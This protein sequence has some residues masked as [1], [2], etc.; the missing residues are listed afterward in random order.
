MGS[1]F[2][3][4]AV[5]VAVGRNTQGAYIDHETGAVDYLALSSIFLSWFLV[6]GV[7]AGLAFT[8]LVW[9]FREFPREAFVNSTTGAVSYLGLAKMLLAWLVA[10]SAATG[11]VVTLLVWSR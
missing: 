7:P 2:G 10:V 8:F 4:L 5:Y 6:L 11:L 9:A 1:A 3:L